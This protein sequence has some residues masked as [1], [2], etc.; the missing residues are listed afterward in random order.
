M[1]TEYLFFEAG[2]S[3]IFHCFLLHDVSYNQ[4]VAIPTPP[5]TTGSKYVPAASRLAHIHEH[6][7]PRGDVDQLTS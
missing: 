6:L 2:Y 7:F 1:D 3:S 4:R 5:A